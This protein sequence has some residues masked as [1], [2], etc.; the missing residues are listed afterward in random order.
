MRQVHKLRNRLAMG[1]G[2][3]RQQIGRRTRNRS[4]QA[5]GMAERL[6]GAARQAVE[7]MRDA[8]RG[9]RG[10]ARR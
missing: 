1:R 10:P 7:H 5:K 4:M 8:G 2:R 6:S 9:F 3:V